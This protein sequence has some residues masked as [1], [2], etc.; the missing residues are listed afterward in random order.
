LTDE[1]AGEAET[2][3][4]LEGEIERLR[5]QLDEARR[6]P[7]NISTQDTPQRVPLIATVTLPMTPTSGTGP[8]VLVAVEDETKVI[9]FQVPVS[10]T[11]GDSFE[12]TVKKGA[13]TLLKAE[14]VKP[15]SAG[16]QRTVSVSLPTRQ[17]SDG[18][19]DVVVKG[20]RGE[21]RTRGF[22]VTRELK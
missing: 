15:R 20:N 17:L 1:R 14:N 4:S 19:Y 11:E 2:L 22:I 9:S 12:V 3:A 7:A 6:R 18:R 21:A 16:T 13:E 8:P 10:E 5:R